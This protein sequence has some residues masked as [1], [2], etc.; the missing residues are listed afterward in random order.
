MNKISFAI[1]SSSIC[2]P[3]KLLCLLS[4]EEDLDRAIALSFAEDGKKP[5]GMVLLNWPE[6]IKV[7]C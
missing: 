2:L 4:K 1:S 7:L 3:D 5:N 6:F